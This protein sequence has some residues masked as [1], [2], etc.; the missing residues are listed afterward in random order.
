[1]HAPTLRDAIARCGRWL[2]T[3]E[4]GIDAACLPCSETVL[5]VN[6]L[7]I[8]TAVVGGLSVAACLRVIV[9]IVAHGRDLV[10][11]RDR[12]LIGLMA[13]NAVCEWF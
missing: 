6:R 8:A 10:S 5:I 3:S 13:A 11:M 7:V 12:I 2:S 9:A 1:V 4:Y